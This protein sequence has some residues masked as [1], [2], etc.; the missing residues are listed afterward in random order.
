MAYEK[1]K[2]EIYQLQGG[3]NTKA[4]QYD[5]QDNEALDLVNMNFFVPG[6][7]QKRPGTHYYLGATVAG[8]IGGLYEF[9]RLNGASYLI[10]TANTNAYV[11]TTSFSS[12]RSGL[13]NNGIF[14]FLTFVDRLFMGNGTNYFKYDGT[15]SSFYSLPPGLSTGI[16]FTI[17][18]AA[19][20]GLSGTYL[21]GYGYQNDRGYYG[22]SS[23][24]VTVV[25]DGIVNG[26]IDYVGLV[27]PPG[28]GILSV[29]FYRSAVDQVNMYGTTQ[30]PAGTATF[31]DNAP[32][33]TRPQPPYIWFTMAPKYIETFNNQV[34]MAGISSA[35]ST[36]YWS[37]IGEP[38]GVQPQS[39]AEFR[40]N[41]GDMI[42]GLKTYNTQLVVT[43]LRSIHRVVGEDPTN[44][45][46]Q[47][48]TDQYGCVSNQAIA[49]YNNI[50]LF[51][52]PKGIGLYDGARVNIISN[53]VE[54]TFISM[55]AFAARDNA[56]A[57]H[58]RK[59][60][61]I[62]FAI[63]CNGATTNNCVVVYDYLSDSFTTYDG[64]NPSTLALASATLTTREMFYGSY[65]GSIAY[66]GS[67]FYGDLGQAFTCYIKTR[68][69]SPMGH[70]TTQQ[71]RRFFLDVDPVLGV[72]QPIDVV[73]VQDF[74]NT[75]GFQDVMYQS[76]FQ[77]R[78]DFG[79]PAKSISVEMSHVSATLPFKVN[80]YTIESRYQRSV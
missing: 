20:G 59:Y 77:S 49:V 41:D 55:N 61:E 36:A 15:N 42:T 29:V 18:P 17:Q 52:D 11:V 50:M 6:S 66:F 25:L 74:G 38:E 78:I 26:S 24:G 58:Y 65:T 37:D 47:E 21:A 3:I 23:P 56:V 62:W 8:R 67:T 68:Y 71:F 34:F 53:R 43:K 28:F 60:N 79:V 64:F 7:Y 30:V 14:D 33:S 39:F 46:L 75:V 12:F 9:E 70:S 32:I 19:G 16:G 22:P 80:G 51:L 57:R 76:P 10:A 63:P 5:T 73:F 2:T 44:F 31:I 4:S 1:N 35:L 13:L 54:P 40:T 27:T 48:I 72:T 45:T 69:L